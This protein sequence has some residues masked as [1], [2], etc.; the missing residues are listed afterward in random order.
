[1]SD[2]VPFVPNDISTAVVLNTTGGLQDMPHRAAA[3][4]AP[5]KKNA[6]C[7]SSTESTWPLDRTVAGWASSVAAAVERANSPGFA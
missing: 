5:P 1:M 6:H 3:Q 2:E 4:R 7:A